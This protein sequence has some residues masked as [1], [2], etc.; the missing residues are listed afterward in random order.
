MAESSE[1]SPAFS[2]HMTQGDHLPLIKKPSD[3][4]SSSNLL[5]FLISPRRVCLSRSAWCYPLLGWNETHVWARAQERGRHCSQSSSSCLLQP[6]SQHPCQP[7][8]CRGGDC[9]G[10]DDLILQ[11]SRDR[12][13]MGQIKSPLIPLMAL[14]KDVGKGVGEMLEDR[15]PPPPALQGRAR[16]KAVLGQILRESPNSSGKGIK[17]CVG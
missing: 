8:I 15:Q 17:L 5:S 13:L 16:A 4:P 14:L 9:V 7:L 6:C 2:E 3:P 10:S 1:V 12:D 11:T